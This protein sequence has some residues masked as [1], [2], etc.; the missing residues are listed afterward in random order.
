MDDLPTDAEVTPPARGRSRLRAS[1]GRQLALAGAGL[2]ALGLGM[3]WADRLSIAD[4]VL[5]RELVRLGLAAN[6]KVVE[7]DT[8][9]AVLTDVVVGDPAHPDAVIPRVEVWA[10]VVGF[11]PAISR[12]DLTSPR[13]FAAMRNGQISFGA[14][15]KF[16]QGGGKASGLPTMDLRISDG[17]MALSTPAGG[18]GAVVSGRGNLAGGFGGALAVSAPHLRGG[19]CAGG[20]RL[21]GRIAVRGGAPMLD[22]TAYLLPASCGAVRLGASQIGVKGKLAPLLDGGDVDLALRTGA[23]DM[24]GARIGAI[25]GPLRLALRD[26]AVNAMGRVAAH[27]L[28]ITGLAAKEVGIEG[29]LRAPLTMARMDGDGTISGRGVVPDKTSYA[30]L[31]KARRGAAGTLA[32]PLIARIESSLRKETPGSRLDGRF[33]LH[34][35]EGRVSFVA[36]LLRLIG[37]SGMPL[38]D[39]D[40]LTLVKNAGAKPSFTGSLRTAAPGLP[41]ILAEI[42]KKGGPIRLSM[43]EYRADNG[44]ALALP[45]IEIVAK[46]SEIRWRGEAVASGALAPGVKVAGLRLPLDGVGGAQGARLWASCVPISFA[47]LEANGLNLSAGKVAACPLS[48]PVL[49]LDRGGWRAGVRLAGLDLNGR[50]GDSPLRLNSGAVELRAG[51]GRDAGLSAQNVAVQLGRPGEGTSL[52]LASVTAQMGPGAAGEFKGLE[53]SLAAVPLLIQNGAGQWRYADGTLALSDVAVQVSDAVKPDRFAPLVAHNASLTM[54]NGVIRA[55]A[56]LRE[57]KGDRQ[58]VQ[59]AITHDLAGAKGFADLTVDGLTFDAKL[60]P[61][62]LTALALGTIANA[63]GRFDGTGRID[64]A[65]GK[66]TSRGRITTQSFDF[67]GLAGPVKGVAGTVEFTDL[68]G[69]VSAPHQT[70]RIGSINPGIEATDGKVRFTMHPGYLLEIEDARWPFLDGEMEMRPTTL[71]LGG[72]AVRRFELGLSGVNAA[73]LITHMEVSNL[74]ATGL[75]DGRIPLIFD[76][77]GGRVSGGELISRPGGGSVSYVGELSYRDLSPMANYAFRTLRDVQFREMRIGLD[78]DLGG[79][80]VTRVSMKG[81]SQGKGASKNFLTRQIAKLPLQFNVNVRAPFYQLIGSLRSLYDSNYIGDP[82]D[83]GLTLPSMRIM[84]TQ[85]PLPKTATIQP[86]VSEHRP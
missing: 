55:D 79:E 60:Q 80:V 34:A 43:A 76:Q 75:F 83:K 84:P 13:L 77:N 12:V 52:K 37:Q 6:Y 78:G 25:T 23:L 35:S 54:K 40:R 17:V 38:L 68:L 59:V 86:S 63:A 85:N 57:P 64:W 30:A 45:R 22:G 2:V 72:A 15:D 7:L 26:S 41:R 8:R 50:M 62:Q 10:G 9:H 24:P 14:L 1:R 73:K 19:G 36:P 31:A 82:R 5:R 44:A 66:V 3:V 71:Q 47:G 27:D 58:I 74:A 11:T 53:G 67:A 4:A 61:D 21:I 46:G 16:M 42:P 81:L 18:V 32:E 65:D 29:R 48:G 56:L 33:N 70:L 20:G 28:A 49:V 69:L 39:G 51:A